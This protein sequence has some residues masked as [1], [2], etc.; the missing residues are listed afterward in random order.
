VPS[1]AP[2]AFVADHFEEVIG[3]RVSALEA[4]AAAEAETV[5][6]HF[7]ELRNFITFSV[8]NQITELRAELKRD[9]AR[10][11]KRLDGLEQRFDGLGQRF[12]GLEQ[13]FDGLA[14]R[15]DGLDLKVA[16]LAVLNHKVDRFDWKVDGLDRKVDAHHE[17]VSLILSDILARLPP[18]RG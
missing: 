9:I 11:E 10:V 8:T 6:E 14:Q 3:L 16:G 18:G 12:D 17:A 4:R 7:V 13:R 1:S 2:E 15:F 5:K